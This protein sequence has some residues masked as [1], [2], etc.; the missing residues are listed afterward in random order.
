MIEYKKQKIK[1]WN[2]KMMG[3]YSKD[4]VKQEIEQQEKD[5]QLRE[6]IAR[7]TFVWDDAAKQQVA[8]TDIW[9]KW[10]GI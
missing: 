7:Q 4:K 8:S 1:Q 3:F 10:K 2:S 9:Q 5:E 6:K